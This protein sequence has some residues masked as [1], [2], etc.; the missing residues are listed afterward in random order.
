MC[1]CTGSCAPEV[2][3]C[4]PIVVDI[5]GNGFSLTDVPNG[6][7]F[8]LEASGNPRQCAWTSIDADEAWLALDRNRNGLIDNGKEMFGNVIAQVPQTG[9]E[10]NGFL[11]LAEYDKIMNGGNNDGKISEQD[12]IFTRLRLWQDT[13]HDGI[14]QTDELKTL[15][16]SGLEKIELDYKESGRIDQHGNQF[17]YRSK[18]RDAHDAQLGRWAWDVFLVTEP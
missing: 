16:E 14:S 6:V 12:F 13:N 10:R 11:A 8:D 5:S 7:T 4:S 17:K 1:A 15:S 9:V 2:G 3:G 18:V